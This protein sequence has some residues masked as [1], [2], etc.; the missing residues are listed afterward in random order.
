MAK[1]WRW[2]EEEWACHLNPLLKGK[3]IEAYTATDEGLSK[4][5]KDLKEALL[6]KL[7]ISPDTYLQHFRAG[8]TPS[9][10]SD[11]DFPPPQGLLLSMGS[12]GGED[13]G[14]DR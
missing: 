11:E 6:V 2:Q 14:Q 8:S 12:T 10:E 1:A 13:T 4:V 3:A 7:D 5:Y 9:R